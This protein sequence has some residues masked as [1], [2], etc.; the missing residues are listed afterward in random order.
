MICCISLNLIHDG[1]DLKDG[2]INLWSDNKRQIDDVKDFFFLICPLSLFNLANWKLLK[3]WN[4][5]LSLVIIP[6]GVMWWMCL[7]HLVCPS[8]YFAFKLPTSPRPLG[9]FVSFENRFLSLSFHF[10]QSLQKHRKKNATISQSH[11]AESDANVTLHQWCGQWLKTKY[12]TF[13]MQPFIVFVSGVK[14]VSKSCFFW[15]HFLKK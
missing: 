4:E 6:L 1:V 10:L 13:A 14:L 2:L 9:C 3:R 12:V 15:H 7:A 8:R 11:L 5:V